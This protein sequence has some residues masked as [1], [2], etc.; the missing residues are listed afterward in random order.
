V[1]AEAIYDF[2]ATLNS[3]E[4]YPLSEFRGKVLL[5]VNVASKCGFTPHYT[6]L[7]TLHETLAPRGFTVLAFPRDQFGHQEPGTDAEIA[8][9]CRQN[10][11]V[12]FPLFAKIEV[13]GSGAHPLYRWLKQQKGGFLGSR[14]KWNFTKFLIDRAGIVRGRF[15]PMVAPERV[16]QK[17]SGLL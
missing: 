12:T 11:A 1:T 8:A 13:N 5:I 9:F 14:I 4:M 3:G 15:A 7:Q 6:G 17:I 16:A 2:S 10:F